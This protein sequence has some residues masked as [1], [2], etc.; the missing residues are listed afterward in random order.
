MLAKTIL[1]QSSDSNQKI[2]ITVG[3]LICIIGLCLVFNKAGVGAWKAF[4]PIYNMYTLCKISFG[5]GWF[6]LL[7]LIPLVGAVV[8]L[9]M[10]IKLSKAFGHGVF[11]GILLT[12]FTPIMLF[13]LGLGSSDYEGVN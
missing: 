8:Y 12:I 13:I 6:F 9:I 2:T 5:S 11:F 4:I 1:S 3:G 7:Y 10:M